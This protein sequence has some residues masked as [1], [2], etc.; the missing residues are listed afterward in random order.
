MFLKKISILVSMCFLLAAC[1]GSNSGPAEKTGWSHLQSISFSAESFNVI[2]GNTVAAEAAG[3]EGSGAVTYSSSDDAIASISASGLVTANDL[4]SVT[5]TATKAA[6]ATYAEATATSN[7]TVDPLQEQTISFGGASVVMVVDTSQ[8]LTASGGAGIGAITYASSDETIV[9]ISSDGVAAA[10]AVGSADITASKAADSEYLAATATIAVT[11]EAVPVVL[12]PATISTTFSGNSKAIIAWDAV[13][14][15]TS[16]NIYSAKQSIESIVNY[17]SLTGGTLT[18]NATSPYTMSGLDNGDAY[19]VVVTA[20]SGESESDP[21]NELSFVPRNP[22]NDT[23][24]LKSGNGTSGINTSCTEAIAGAKQDCAHG[25]DADDTVVKLG[26][27]AAGFDF[28]KLGADG[29]ALAVQTGTWAAN[30]TEAAGTKWSCLKD[31]VTGLVWEAKTTAGTHSINNKTKWSERDLL[32]ATS[33]TEELCGIN[34]WRVPSVVELATIVNNNKH[35]PTFDTARFPNGKSQSYWSSNPVVGVA[36]NA[37]TMNF[38][39][40][41]QNKKAKSSNFQVML[42]SGSSSA[43]DALKNERFLV[44]SD[45]TVTDHATGLMWR[46]CPIGQSGAACSGTATTLVWGGTMKAAEKSTFA[47]YIDWRLANSKEVASIAAFGKASPHV[48]QDIFPSLTMSVWTSS[49]VV[50]LSQVNQAWTL[51]FTSGLLVAKN[52]TTTKHAQLLV[53]VAD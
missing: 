36:A 23:G 26:T 9:T 20:S 30:G 31:N 13:E 22:L 7:V 5:I 46:Q 52:R 10:I 6:D 25:R 44:N 16:Y 4:G 38:Y 42:V 27:G 33:N 29:E 18:Q 2:V 28:T 37:W 40:G 12:D 34:T 43:T 15:A 17:A 53:R 45:G 41:I 51:D 24:I 47:G 50:G 49:P 8:T 39:A 32:A 21:S 1:G 11:V 19:Y 3:G 48:N 14:N 35:N